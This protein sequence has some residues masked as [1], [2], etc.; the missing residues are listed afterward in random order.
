MPF[1]LFVALRY[2]RDGRVQT[3]LILAG[4]GVGVGVI[5]FLSALI[6]GLQA[7][8]IDRTLGSQAHIVVRPPEEM[9]RVLP[10]PDG[11]MR[12]TEV[13][14]PPQRI[15]A[16]TSGKQVEVRLRR[17][18]GV[19]AV[20][21]TAAGPAL[22]VRGP[23][24]ISV[25]IR[26]IEL[27]TYRT[28]VDVESRLVDGSFD[29]A[30]FHAVV[31]T[32]LADKLG[33]GV[34]GRI[35][36]QVSGG[37]GGTYTVSGIFDYGSRSLNEGLVFVSLRGAQTLFALE[38]GFSTLE[39]RVDDIFE[40]DRLAAGIQDRLGLVADS[41][42]AQNRDLMTG[43]RSQSA[44]S[45]MI[46]VFV[47]LAVALGIASVLAVSVVQKAKEIGI[48]RATGTRTVSVTRIFLL[49]GAILGTAG[50][51]IGIVLGT[52]LALFFASLARNPDG[53]ATF[54]VALTTFLYGRS[55]AVALVEGCCRPSFP[56]GTRRA[57]TPPR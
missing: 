43:L 4:I 30:G 21:P 13:Q 54:P 17:L 41:W 3:W 29:L 50:S 12:A 47:I 55:V 6:V 5:I 2:L 25:T 36:L 31:G 56:P 15:R 32:E 48:L 26:G 34:G 57:W 40:A 42:M 44:S 9:P 53:S 38:G 20:A 35:R 27:E 46:Q 18:P 24:T 37:R 23:G 10:V 11:D 8:I 22:A 45:V 14:R 1:E 7:S 49:Q 52:V 16:I 39:V 28:I 33:I 19:V 51:F